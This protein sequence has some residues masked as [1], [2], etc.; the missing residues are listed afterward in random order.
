MSD[1]ILVTGATGFIGRAIVRRLLADGRRVIAVARPRDGQSARARMDA[2]VARG[3]RL[4]V[5][6]HDFGRQALSATDV[7]WLRATVETVIHAAG[8]TQFYPADV[9]EFRA[10]HVHGPVALLAALAGGRLRRF[11]HVSTAFVCGDREGRVLE[12]DGDV[13]QRFHNVYE[14]VKL[15]AEAAL[16]RQ[17]AHTE[18]DLVVLRPSIVVGD[19]PVT[20]GGGPSNL[21]FDAVRLLAAAAALGGVDGLRIPGAPD[22]PF[23]IVPIEYV[24]D[25][26]LALATDRSAGGG[27]YHL[28]TS[29]PPT[30]SE[31]L[32]WIADAI[33]LRGARMAFAEEL[34]QDASAMERQVMRMIGGYRE[35]LAQDVRFDDRCA[36]RVLD[37]AGVPAVTLDAVAVVTLVR[38]AI[39]A[40]RVP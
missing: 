13:G 25:A 28:V 39:A 16:T 40:E 38:G 17:A 18:V 6:E 19:A 31:T 5:V 20:A 29:E 15:D 9:D 36:R 14:R 24:V 30:Q 22:A 12:T 4:A 37:R 27:A 3:G 8:D 32:A 1:G 21:F 33:G 11:A 2:D 26:A 10:G 7:A 34:Q 35:Y 23:N